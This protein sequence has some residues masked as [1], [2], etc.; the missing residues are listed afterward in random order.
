VIAVVVF[1]FFINLLMF[2][3]PLYMLQGYD[4]VLSSRHETTLLIL[5][6]MAAGALAVCGLLELVRSRVLVR[7]GLRLDALLSAPTFHAVFRRSVRERGGASAQAL[8]D[9]DAVR[10]F[11]A[12]SGLIAL[13][14]APWVPLFLGLIFLFHPVLGLVALMAAVVIFALAAANE[15]TT[16]APLARA[17]Q[18]ANRANSFVETS[19]RNAEAAAAMGMLDNLQERWAAARHKEVLSDQARAS[20]RAGS[21]L[22]ASKSLRMVFQV[23]V[24]GS[25]GYLV[26]QG[27]TTPGTMI[28]ASVVMSRALAPVEQAVGQW[29]NFV[30]AHEAY[31]RLKRT[32]DA[33]PTDG[34]MALPAPEGRIT[35]ERAAIVAPG[36]TTPV[37][38]GA[39]FEIAPGELFGIIGPSGAGKSSVARAQIEIMRGELEGLR[40]L[41]EKSY[42]AQ[43]RVLER[44]RKLAGLEGRAGRLTAEIAK[45]RGGIGERE[46]KIERIRQSYRKRWRTGCARASSESPSCASSWPRRACA[47]T[48]ATSR[49]SSPGPCTTCV[50]PRP[51]TWSPRATRSCRSSPSRTRA[52]SPRA[53]PRATSDSSP[54]ARSPRCA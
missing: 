38:R 6:L 3:V 5:T 45:A 14:D 7:V 1:S 51:A 29:K 35:V 2:T 19:L 21:I 42:Y 15:I 10:E 39:D 18:G 34:G 33:A 22:S 54:T 25:G 13:C 24:L 11:T 50:W 52:W 48:A 4:R 49:R 28:A 40:E 9:L 26:L 8:R 32:L 46:A 23:A 41:A 30:N 31:G 43:T 12:G 44:E 27:E 20:E 37:V 17:S 16:R 36:G 47:W 53:S